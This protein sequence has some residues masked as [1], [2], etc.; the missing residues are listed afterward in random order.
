VFHGYWNDPAA[1]EAALTPDGFLKTGDIAVVDDDGHLYLVD[2]AKDIVIVSGFN[3]YPAEVE[4]VLLEHPAI[5]EAAVIGVPHPYSGEAVKAY[6]VVA[7]GMSAE[8]DDVIQ[9]CADRLAR[10]KCPEKV[11]FVDEL[12]QGAAGKVLRRALH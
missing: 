2:R 8:E 4:G 10:Y 9:W 11:M 12:P 6:V 5:A 1:T 7:P 3:V